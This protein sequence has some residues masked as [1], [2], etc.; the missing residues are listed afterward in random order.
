MD[1]IP[2]EFEKPPSLYNGR[3]NL[4]EEKTMN[5]EN[6]FLLHDRIPIKSNDY[7]DALQGELHDTTLSKAYF[8]KENQEI[9]QNGLR[10]GVYDM[11]K[12]K[13][14]I[15]RQDP[16]VIQMVMRS[17]FLEH[18]NFNVNNIPSQ[19]QAINALVLNYFV[20]KVF[21]EVEGYMK[22]KRDIS[23][24]AQPMEHPVL[25]RV[26]NQLQPKIGFQ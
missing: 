11:S 6:A 20:P 19:I 16:N 23:T 14:L 8:S 12:E 3:V 18:A 10:K 1:Y 21:G 2:K 7:N 9:I 24:I 5:H 15:D 26:T 25:S 17:V 4:M 13:Y 22:Y